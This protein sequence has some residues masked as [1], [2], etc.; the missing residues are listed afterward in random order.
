MLPLF[1]AAVKK[2]SSDLGALVKKAYGILFFFGAGVALY[3]AIAAKPV[4]TFIANADYLV[5]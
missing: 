1:T 5:T 3:L 4:I 2:K